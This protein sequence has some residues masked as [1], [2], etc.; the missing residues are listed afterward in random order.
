MFEMRKAHKQITDQ[1]QLEA[2]LDQAPVLRLAMCKD[3]QPY[4]TP[5]NFGRIGQSIYVHTCREGLKME[6][7]EANPRV[8][9]EATAVS[10]PQPGPTPCK[11]DWRYR[12]VIG[13]GVA[14]VVEDEAEKT[15]ALRAI[16]AHYDPTA[17]AEIPPEKMRKAA[18]LRLDVQALS[19]RANL[20]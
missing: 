4:V 13:F 7:I 17:S 1:A 8:C 14:Q 18:V 9:F 19:G 3:G 6:F 20:A 2:I 10:E 11:W 15:A 5:L 12:S 16:T